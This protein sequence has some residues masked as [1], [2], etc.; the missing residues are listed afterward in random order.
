M[1]PRTLALPLLFSLLAGCAVEPDYVRPAPALPDRFIGEAALGQR[2]ATANAELVA[3]WTGFGDAQLA[4]YV[5]E[6]LKQ[7]LDLAQASARVA[8]ARA[9]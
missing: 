4:R 8:Q 2:S 7:N 1:S 3:W 6:A 5:D 9:G